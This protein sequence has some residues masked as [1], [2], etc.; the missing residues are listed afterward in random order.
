MNEKDKEEMY[1]A[2]LLIRIF[3]GRK[4]FLLQIIKA[5]DVAQVTR[6]RNQFLSSSKFA[7]KFNLSQISSTLIRKKHIS[8]FP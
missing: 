8:E 7:R 4:I 2:G 3:T 1:M 5:T 6:P